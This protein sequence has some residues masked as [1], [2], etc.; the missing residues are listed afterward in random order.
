[1]KEKNLKEN[2]LAGR[3]NAIMF[4]KRLSQADLGR[5]A[6]VSRSAVNRWFARGTIPVECASKIADATGSSLTWILIGKDERVGDLS[7]DEHALVDVFRRMPPIERRN[8]LA[9][10]Q[11]RYEELRKFYTSMVFKPDEK[12]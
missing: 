11:M 12:K 2:D 7:E 4:E 6:G 10:F 3:L 1:M 5:I 9:A 8:M